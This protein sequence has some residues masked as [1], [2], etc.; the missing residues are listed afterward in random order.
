MLLL[1]FAMVVEAMHAAAAATSFI[2]QS[3]S[4]PAIYCKSVGLTS[5]Q[6]LHIGALKM[7]VYNALA[8]GTV[9]ASSRKS[10]ICSSG[11]QVCCFSLALCAS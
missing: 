9:S 10:S 4:L 3:C 1:E 8:S 2:V 7:F 6:L 11:A 5:N